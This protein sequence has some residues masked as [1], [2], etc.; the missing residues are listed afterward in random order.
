MSKG[1]STRERI[2]IE[3]AKLFNLYGYHRCSLQDIMIATNLKKGGIYNH[4]KNK[5]EIAIESFEYSFQQVYKRFRERLHICNNSTEKLFAIVEIFEGYVENPLFEG[6][7]PIVNTAIDT[8]DSY[9]LLREKAKEALRFLEKYIEIKIKE[10]IE[11]KEFKENLDCGQISAFI[12]SS[13][14]G[15]V[16]LTRLNEDNKYLKIISNHITE[17]ILNKIIK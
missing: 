16:I 11:N 12:L 17:Y 14:E 5:D 8:T 2:V 3:S 1:I 4:F 13:F 7:C 15:A 6:G 10:G 9:P